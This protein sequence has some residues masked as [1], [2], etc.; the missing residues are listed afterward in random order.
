LPQQLKL[1]VYVLNWNQAELTVD[2][3]NSLIKQVGSIQFN[4][5]IIDNGSSDNSISIFNQEFPQ[6]TILKNRK[7]LGFQGGMNTGIRHALKNNV[8]YALLLNNDTI[9]DPRMVQELLN[10]FPKDA[11]LASPI[12]YYYDSP[13]TPWSIGGDINPVFLE[14]TRLYRKNM[15]VPNNILSRDFLP[16]C[17]WLIKRE[18]LEQVGFL[19]ENFFPIYYDDL[20]YCLR[21]KQLGFNS[22]LIPQAK[23]WHKVSLSVGGEHSPKER[24]LMARNSGYYFRKHMRLWQS[25]LIIMYRL[26]SF[27]L[28]T[29]RLLLK[30]KFSALKQYYRGTIDGWFRKIYK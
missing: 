20:D 27:I 23:L 12:V 16:S 8:D 13:M 11:G 17:A 4:I 15:P 1:N 24:Y 19:D 3:V 14:V 6:I 30:G 18:V 29:F 26:G 7:N 28:W 10:N 21:I 25:P 9:A 22:Y 5:Y 2:C